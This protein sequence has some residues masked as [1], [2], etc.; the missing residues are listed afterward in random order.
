MSD[1]DTLTKQFVRDTEVFADAFNY[2][3]HDGECVIQ[4]EQLRAADTTEVV[5]PYGEDK[6]GI[7]IQPVQKFRDAFYSIMTDG[8]RVYMLCGIENQT[9]PHNAMPI[10]NALYDIMEYAA[11]VQEAAK[12]HRDAKNHGTGHDFLS[13]LHRTDKLIPVYTIVVYWGSEEW[14][15]PKS[16]F[17]M[18]DV[19]D[20]SDYFG[21]NDW[22]INLIIPN[23]L[24]DEEAS[25]KFRSDLGKALIYV[26]NMGN[27]DKIKQLAIDERFRV[28]KTDTVLMLNE[29]MNADFQIQGKETTTDMCYAIQKIKEDAAIISAINTARRYNIKESS[30]L[31]DIMNQFKLSLEDAKAYMAGK[32]S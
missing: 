10:R 1:T 31:D 5:V 12:A 11:Q 7:R 8:N 30:I 18:L 32:N 21:L 9:E 26:K 22:K 24:T 4:P 2:Y 28:L 13:G 17:E 6:T 3:L 29:V 15:A 20:G 23:E 27:P 19:E 16:L 25:Q 14:D